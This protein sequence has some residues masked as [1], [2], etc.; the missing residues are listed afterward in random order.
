MIKKIKNHYLCKLLVILTLFN[1]IN[2]SADFYTPINGNQKF[3]VPDPID[4]MAE[5]LLEYFMDMDQ[6][7]IP[8]TE[9]PQEQRKF[10]DL[11]FVYQLLWK[12]QKLENF[13]DALNWNSFYSNLFESIKI[14]LQAPPPKS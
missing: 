7:T 6:E 10:K 12:N 5:L 14:D 13:E 4:T 9:V 3:F 2:L 8:D 11:K 1:F